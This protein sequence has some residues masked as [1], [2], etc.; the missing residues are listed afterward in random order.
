M[1]EPHAGEPGTAWV[2]VIS[3]DAEFRGRLRRVLDD[4]SIPAEL[5]LAIDCPFSAISDV[6]LQEI[7]RAA[8]EVVVVDLEG[9]VQSGLSFIQELV[10][11]GDAGAVLAAGRDLSQE[12][13]LKALQAGVT[14][15]LA[16]PM[17]RDRALEALQRVLRKAGRIVK[18]EEEVEPGRVLA[19]FGAKGG[20]GTTA[21]ATNLAVEIRRLTGA[22]T[23]LLDLDVEQ[24]ETALLLGVDPQL[25][26][27]DLLR[28]YQPEVQGLLA[29]CIDHHGRSGIDLLAGPVQPSA[30]QQE[31]LDLLSGDAMRE[32]LAFLRMHYDF[33]V[34]DRPKSFHP[35]F[36]CVLEEAD[37]VYLVT[38]PDLQA[39]RNIA[40]SLPLLR[41]MSS[42]G[43]EREI[44]LVVNRYP[45]QPTIS[46]REVADTVGLEVFHSLGADFFPLNES[47]HERTPAVLRE[48]SQFSRDVKTLAEKVTRPV[49]DAPRKGLLQGIMG[50]VRNR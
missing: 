29:A 16:K 13:L 34:I 32:V 4:P 42:N 7:R 25:S 24:G 1:V 30:L 45:A 20:V 46:L 49:E 23:L 41:R 12:V 3:T 15:M 31:D 48:K 35:A 39:L 18:Q 11:A 36:N 10:D 40:R 14:E 47:I 17:E 50:V 21:L 6:E 43:G 9:G 8:P 37:E 2:A 26:L 22:R 5:A 28:N 38:T 19:L 44:R 33:I 27:L